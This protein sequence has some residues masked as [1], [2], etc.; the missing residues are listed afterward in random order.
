MVFPSKSHWL[1]ALVASQASAALAATTTRS[2]TPSR[3]MNA[4]QSVA[5]SQSQALSKITLPKAGDLGYYVRF[6]AQK[7]FECINSV[8]LDVNVS[9]ATI[10]LLKR[11]YEFDTTIAY[12][13]D[14]PKSYQSLPIDVMGRLDQVAQSL[15]DGKYNSTYEMEAAIKQIFITAREGHMKY[16]GGIL[17]IFSWVLPDGLISVSSDGKSLPEVYA[18]N[19]VLLNK[20]NISPI[21]EI[22]NQTVFDYLRD[23]IETKAPTGLIESHADWNAIMYSSQV[24]FG[25]IGSG[26]SLSYS[27]TLF[28]STD[29]YNGPSITVRFSNGTSSE[30]LYQA[31]SSWNLLQQNLTSPNAI[32]NARVYSTQLSA[33]AED[34]DE[35]STTTTRVGSRATTSAQSSAPTSTSA[36]FVPVIGYPKDPIVKQENFTNGGFVS[37]YLLQNDSVGVLSLPSFATAS[38]S[39]ASADSQSFSDAV[40]AFIREAKDAGMKKIIIDLSGNTGG[41]FLL[42]YNTFRQFFPDTLPTLSFR[43]RS[44]PSLRTIGRIVTEVLSDENAP[45]DIYSLF[46]GP[47]RA[48]SLNTLHTMKLNGENWASYA[49]FS[50]PRTIHGDNFTQTGRYS[51]SDPA[52]ASGVDM[53]PYL[54][55]YGTNKLSYEQPWKGEDITL[56]LDGWCAS[57]CTLFAELMKTDGGVKSV[58]VG[59]IPQYGPM[60]GIC[61]TRGSNILAH[62]FF[63]SAI[64]AINSLMKYAETS[65]KGGTAALLQQLNLT[66]SDIRSLPAPLSSSPAKVFDNSVNA[67]DEI[68]ASSPD[69]PLAFTY[70]AA[71]CRI[72]W[73]GEMARDLTQLWRA[74]S[75]YSSGDTSVCVEGSVDGPGSGFNETITDDPGYSYNKTWENANSTKVP[76]N[77]KASNGGSSDDSAGLASYHVSMTVLLGAMFAALFFI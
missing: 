39:S 3:T 44:T 35:T 61:G 17:G 70:E 47:G 5:S 53:G 52:W 20:N 49:D 62:I 60:Q 14:P 7:A 68:R 54:A 30:W 24:L 58:V 71:N 63:S 64:T 51:L 11:Y 19:D 29:F 13:K 9:I 75:K 6:D 21:V 66:S 40:A 56:L 22:N 57:T 25:T 50:S 2:A 36:Q 28:Q 31:T 33:R 27:P 42:G 38:S 18:S 15:S 16:N 72:F 1:A 76:E 74:V 23:Y 12:L 65:I 4:C 10:D 8:P 37:G 48:A 67:L 26:S 41:T 59:G 34:D 32:F 77:K 73:T 43:A 46:T 45:S 69:S 55:G